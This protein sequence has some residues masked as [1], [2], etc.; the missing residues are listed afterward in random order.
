MTK[1]HT[2]YAGETEQI[3]IDLF[4]AH[5]DPFYNECSAF[6]RLTE[7]KLNRKYAVCCYGYTAISPDREL[8]IEREF[9]V[10]FGCS[11]DEYEQPVS[12]HF[13][14]LLKNSFETIFHWPKKFW[15]RY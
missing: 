6:G 8:E 15:A 1:K 2:I 4:H 14:P 10:D 7:Q 9:H 11:D 12:S 3:P 13:E 5:I